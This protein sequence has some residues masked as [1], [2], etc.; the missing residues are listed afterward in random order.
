MSKKGLG[1]GIEALI[2]AD[3]Q[4]LDTPIVELD[5]T[6]IK[7]DPLQP[8]QVFD[9][10]KIDELAASLKEHGVIQPLI[11]RR[12]GGT[13][14]LVAGER[15]LRAALKA[16]IDKVPVVLREMD[17]REAMEVSLV[18]NLQREELGPL[19]QA[20]AFQR[21]ID[22]FGL[23]QEEVAARVGKSRPEVANTVRLLKLEPEVKKLIADGK[24]TGGHGRALVGLSR[25]EQIKAANSVVAKGLSVRKTE[26]LVAGLSKGKKV[27]TSPPVPVR[28]RDA[29]EILSAAIGN[30][31]QVKVH[32]EKG[33][34]TIPFF[35][36]EDLE[37]I[38]EM[39]E[40][41]SKS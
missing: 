28:R 24:L 20:D 32:G 38:V 11:V 33:T 9:E 18:E 8:R 2:P 23:T 30:Q 36:E 26:E 39:I 13:Y 27:K 14:R 10:A 1:R 3:P 25:A 17:D 31:V 6:E 19:E 41:G 35:S 21:L 16:G 15:R 5:P 7:P 37:R 22:E 12:V 34:I 29:E 4:S 40:K